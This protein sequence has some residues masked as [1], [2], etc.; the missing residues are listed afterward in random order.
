ME[1]S[2]ETAESI[3]L[4]MTARGFSGEVKTMTAFKMKG[5]DYAWMGFAIFIFLLSVQL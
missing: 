1:R 2:L 5:R 3:Y 4:A